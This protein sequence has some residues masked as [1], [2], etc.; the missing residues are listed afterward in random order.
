[1][2][3]A[4]GDRRIFRLPRELGT[5]WP[6]LNE[7]EPELTG[8]YQVPVKEYCRIKAKSMS[9]QEPGCISND[10]EQ[11]N[12]GCPCYYTCGKRREPS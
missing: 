6:D 8:N 9:N 4:G 5:T 10:L 1:M 3:A 7:Q 11:G 12:G 2:M